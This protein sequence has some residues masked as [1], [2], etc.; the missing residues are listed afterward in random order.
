MNKYFVSCVVI[1][2]TIFFSSATANPSFAGLKQ[3]IST[4]AASWA[5]E[6]CALEPEYQVAFLNFFEFTGKG[7][8]EFLMCDEYIKSKPV[9]L[10]LYKKLSMAYMDIVI[11]YAENM[12]KK[13]EKKNANEK[14]K[15][16]LWKKLQTKIQELMNYINEIYYETLYTEI[17]KNKNLSPA[18]MF[19]KNGLIAS[20]KRTRSLPKPSH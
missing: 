1:V 17:A 3:E 2:Q 5:R 20:E 13:I 15:H 18:Y 10:P 11:K 16:K 14:E 12:E 7:P 8:E 9:M 19:D 6:V 4:N